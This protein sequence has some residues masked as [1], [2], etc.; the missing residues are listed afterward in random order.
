MITDLGNGLFSAGVP[1]QDFEYY[2]APA[3][4][5]RQRQNNWCWAASVQMVLNYHSLY[6]TQEAI[7]QRLFGSIYNSPA[8]L[9]GIM[10]TLSGWAY[11]YRGRTSNIYAQSYI[12]NNSMLVND[13]AFNWPLIIGFYGRPI[14]HACV[15]TAI[16]Y[17][18]TPQQQPYIHT[19]IIRDPWP[20]YESRQEYNWNQL[21]KSVNFLI[22]VYVQRN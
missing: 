6:V 5:G 10:T 11:D 7:V 1:T 21:L 2:A 8:N 13:L 15:L 22:R 16:Y 17:S 9:N 18:M 12:L 3:V 4:Q 14:G 20:G 19:G